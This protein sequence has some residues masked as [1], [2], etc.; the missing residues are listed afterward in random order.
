M[1]ALC[2]LWITFF[3]WFQLP[4]EGLFHGQI[5]KSFNPFFIHYLFIYTCL[6]GK[7]NCVIGFH[8]NADYR[9]YW[10]YQLCFISHF[11]S[12]SSWCKCRTLQQLT[13]YHP[14]DS[15]GPSC[16][17]HDP[18][19]GRLAGF[20]SLLV[21]SVCKFTKFAPNFAKMFSKFPEFPELWLSFCF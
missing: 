6:P 15:A 8:N 7:L 20:F 21:F 17:I 9:Y 13:N 16:S 10:N 18:A 14:R 5:W 19:D 11:D 2:R 4:A 12:A 1:A 3:E